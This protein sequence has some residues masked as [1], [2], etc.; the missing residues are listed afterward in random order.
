MWSNDDDDIEVVGIHPPQLSTRT[1]PDVP[2]AIADAASEAWKCFDISAYRGAVAV[3]RSVIEFAAKDKGISVRGVF[4]K[5]EQLHERQW[6]RED[7]KEAAHE[8]RHAGNE[9]VHADLG[10]EILREQVEELLTIMDEILHEVYTSR[11][12]TQRVREAREAREAER[13]TP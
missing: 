6:I 10:A 7:M 1:F 13:S 3:A 12:R 5:I 9:T 2:P 11:A 8:I 4:N